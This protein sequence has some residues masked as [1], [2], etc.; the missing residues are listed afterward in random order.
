MNLLLKKL[1]AILAERGMLNANACVRWV[2]AQIA[3]G[4]LA[5]SFKTDPGKTLACL[6]EAIA[7][8]AAAAFSKF[9]EHPEGRF[10]TLTQG[11]SSS[12]VVTTV[13]M[14]DEINELAKVLG[15]HTAGFS[16]TDSVGRPRPVE[17]F[18]AQLV[19]QQ[20]IAYVAE[21]LPEIL[22]SLF[23]RLNQNDGGPQPV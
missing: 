19:L 20:L 2:S 16:A 10:G 18:I 5:E 22:D 15:V 9:H 14:V 11:V 12:A 7:V 4:T 21:H 8:L 17:G 1:L 3:A 13:E 6:G 23:D